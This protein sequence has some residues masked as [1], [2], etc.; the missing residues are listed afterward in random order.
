MGEERQCRQCGA[1]L[2]SDG[3]GDF[4]PNCVIGL[5]AEESQPNGAASP[6]A[7]DAPPLAGVPRRGVW[8]R[9]MA[10]VLAAGGGVVL[11]GIALWSLSAPPARRPPVERF[12]ITTAPDVTLRTDGIHPSVAISPDGTNIVYAAAGP[13]QDRQLYLR[14]V[15][16]LDAT[17][18]RGTEGA[19][20]PVFSPD[21]DW[22]AFLTAD[23]TLQKVSILGGRSIP[24]VEAGTQVRGL[25]WGPD[26]NIVFGT[27]SGLMRVPAGG[28]EPRLLTTVDAERGETAHIWP[29]V[30]PDHTVL[31]TAW[32]DSEETSEVA[33]LS[34][35][36]G[37]VGHLFWGGSHPRYS[38]TGHIIY[39]VLG[40]LWAVGYNRGDPQI[41]SRNP[42]PVLENV[43]TKASG[44]GNFAFSDSGSLVYVSGQD[45]SGTERSLVWVDLQGREQLLDLPPRAFQGP[46]LSPDGRRV[47]VHIDGGSEGGFDVWVADVE[48]GTISRL[49]TDAAADIAP[50]WSPDGAQ[51]VFSS[52]RQDAW[53]L[54]LKAAD[55]TGEAEPLLILEEAQE[56]LAYGW[57]PDGRSLVFEYAMPGTGRNIGTLSMN[58]ESAWE[59]LLDTEANESG[60]ALSPD[61]RWLAYASDETGSHEIYVQRFPDL[62]RKV[63]ISRETGIHPVW[64][65]DGRQLFY[66][67]PASQG[68][69]VM[70]VSIE[71]DETLGVGVTETLFS[72][73]YSSGSALRE[74]DLAPHGELFIRLKRETV[75]MDAGAPVT[76]IVLVQHW[77]D[78]LRR[79]V[80][81]P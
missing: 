38:R 47:A 61:G 18:L 4:C 26:D 16:Q 27:P 74:F 50:V 77:F 28:G 9:S 69:R 32:S 21:G 49:T 25:S 71:M 23:S 20:G 34:L 80:P 12:V 79:L 13:T 60:P 62:G 36:T 54:F 42:V 8:T 43:N 3:P 19:N 73:D 56:L 81:I 67:T 51:I 59:P 30:L 68:R 72:G 64:S 10:V 46:R 57:S 22:V 70:V 58:E 65:P 76:Q 11:T 7:A 45:N 29:E 17:P 35:E 53:G 5:V 2:P 33:V 6:P 1:T 37:E 63:P 31:F 48:R 15:G 66:E 44:A 39:G 24:I 14:H 41:T 78:E 55:G 52:R 75:A 40:T